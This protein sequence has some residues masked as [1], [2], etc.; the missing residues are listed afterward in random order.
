M[1]EYAKGRQRAAGPVVGVGAAERGL[2]V[3]AGHADIDAAGRDR[4]EARDAGGVSAID[5]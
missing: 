5:E 1:A 3:E 2:V 4:A